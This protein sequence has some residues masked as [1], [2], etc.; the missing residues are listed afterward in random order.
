[1]SENKKELLTTNITAT[2]INVGDEEKNDN[3]SYEY[4][5]ENPI[6]HKIDKDFDAITTVNIGERIYD[7]GDEVNLLFTEHIPHP[8]ETKNF[9]IMRTPEYPLEQKKKKRKKRILTT[10]W[11]LFILGLSCLCS[12]ST[13]SNNVSNQ[14]NSKTQ[15]QTDAK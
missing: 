5:F 10:L 15:I 14:N 6:T 11:V 13:V 8:G 12:I 7:I 2:V 3:F 1:M 9:T 4:E